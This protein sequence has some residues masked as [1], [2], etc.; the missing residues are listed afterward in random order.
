[1]MAEEPAGMS[2]NKGTRLT[3]VADRAAKREDKAIANKDH[4]ASPLLQR[5]EVNGKAA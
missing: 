2:K 3:R 4:R 5:Q 1:M